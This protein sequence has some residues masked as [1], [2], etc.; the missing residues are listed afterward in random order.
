MTIP[1]ALQQAFP[2]D[3]ALE[4]TASRTLDGQS[5]L[6]LGSGRSSVTCPACETET[7][8]IHDRAL[9]TVRDLACFGQEVILQLRSRRF[10]C[11]N[12]A[13]PKR[14]FA[15]RFPDLVA[16]YGRVTT[17]VQQL[18]RTL[19]LSVGGVAGARLARH[20][21]L[22]VT[23]DRLLRSLHALEVAPRL[24]P[25]AI[26]VDDFAFR[27]GFSYGTIIVDL[28]AGQPVDLLPGRKVETV[29]DWL[30]RHPQVKFVAR[31]RSKE[32]ARGITLGAPQAQ[33]VLDRPTGRAKPV[34]RLARP[35]ESGGSH[36]A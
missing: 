1:N 36:G 21:A 12:A 18:L 8:S 11:R 29:A 23:P 13:C 19:A 20:L 26:G 16:S 31:D 27:R 9:R 22:R 3:L 2:A 10:R 32:Y 28:L 6:A 33:Q 30:A 25:E 24:V 34:P 15:E 5:L 17:R 7:G 14:T 35:E 4:I